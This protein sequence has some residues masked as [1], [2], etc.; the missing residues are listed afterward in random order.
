MHVGVKGLTRRPTLSTPLRLQGTERINEPGIRSLRTTRILEE[1]MALTIE[2]GIYFIEAV[3]F[4][5]I[6]SHFLVPEGKSNFIKLNEKIASSP[7]VSIPRF[8]YIRT[9]ETEW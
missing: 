6:I 5:V 8:S 7:L 2:P 4:G 1:N 9:S 3:S